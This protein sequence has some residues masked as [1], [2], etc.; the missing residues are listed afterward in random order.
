M[1][2]SEFKSLTCALKHLNPLIVSNEVAMVFVIQSKIGILTL[3][4]LMKHLTL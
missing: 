2:N 1:E 4:S 3:T